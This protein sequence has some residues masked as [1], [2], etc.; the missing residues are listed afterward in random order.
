MGLVWDPANDNFIFSY[1]PILQT[2]KITKRSVLSM[3]ARFYDP[4]GLKGSVLTKAKILRQDL[5]KDKLYW[6]EALPQVLH[7]ILLNKILKYTL[8][9]TYDF[10]K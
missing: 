2:N 7:R 3:I 6:D 9:V 5:W 4:L 1:I 8:L 10:I